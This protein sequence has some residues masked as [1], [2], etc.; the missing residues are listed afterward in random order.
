LLKDGA[1]KT[2]SLLYKW[3]FALLLYFVVIQERTSSTIAPIL[4]ELKTKKVPPTFHK[5]N[6][7]TKGFQEIVDAYG[8]ASY[9]E[10]NPGLFTTITFPFL[11]AVMFGDFGHGLLLFSLAAWIVMNE[12]EL[13]KKDYGEMWDMFFGG[14]YIVLLMGLFS[15]FTGLIYNDVFSQAMTLLPSAYEKFV[16]VP[17]EPGSYEGVLIKGR[18]YGFGLDPVT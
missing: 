4:N 12:K 16:P 3:L 11:F 7:F 14:R 1:Q 15:I 2:Q 5:T 8:M 13:Q 9:G 6:K 17:N 10:V 18:T